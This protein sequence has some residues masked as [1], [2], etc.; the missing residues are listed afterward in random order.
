M[1]FTTGGKHFWTHPSVLAFSESED[2]IQ[3][4]S[5]RASSVMLNAIQS[6]LAGPP[7]D[8]I[9]L[10]AFLGIRVTPRQEIA[11]ARILLAPDNNLLIEYNP[12][13]PRARV[14]YSVAHELGHALFAD[15]DH[16]TRYRLQ[17][18]EQRKDDW[19]LEMLCN[20]AAAEFLMP[21]AYFP[22]IADAE[23]TIEQVLK[24][25]K[26]FD[27][28]TEA[29]LLRLARK[30]SHRC[31]VFAA[32]CL[33]HERADRHYQLD[34]L[35]NSRAGTFRL[36]P[37]NRLPAKSVITDCSAIGYTAVGEEHWSGVAENMRVECVGVLPFAGGLLPRVVGLLLPLGLNEIQKPL[38]KFVRGDATDP[39]GD[40]IRIVAHVVNDKAALWGAGFG[41]AVRKNWPEVQDAF[42]SWT[43]K[44][45]GV[46]KLG[47]TY[48]TKM[49][50][51]LV[52]FQ[53]VAQH[54]Y[55]ASTS[56]R[57]RYGA[58]RTCLERL[59][60]FTIEHKA[61]V[62][63]PRIGAGQGGGAWGL[64][65][66]LIDETLCGRGIRV[67]VYDLPDSLPVAS[68]SQRSLFN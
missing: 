54:G 38:L 18:H 62:H 23:L 4:V 17:R 30:T 27:V 20:I 44:N 63:M 55:G 40:E 31:A 28:S 13:K 65:Q 33:T 50:T 48:H 59:A 11:D 42:V 58:L 12:T 36:S 6:G 14:R 39:R 29:I 37:G 8:P 53:M 22:E 45:S 19:Q 49:S 67:T 21:S 35:V 52:F 34:Y 64:V 25:R 24:L 66:Q 10:A 32:S 2:P 57:L 68:K 26:Q 15:C 46:L 1:N 60:D 61:A 51:D 43:R 41:L 47:N 7:F 56:A 5:A 9:Q 16:Q 3:A